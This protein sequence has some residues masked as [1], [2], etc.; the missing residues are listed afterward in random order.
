MCKI[1]ANMT[2]VSDV[3]PGPLVWSN[4]ILIVG[5]NK[6]EIPTYQYLP[7]SQN[8]ESEKGNKLAEELSTVPS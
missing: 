3:A 7:I 2:Q 6:K 1:L 8:I 4:I 5:K